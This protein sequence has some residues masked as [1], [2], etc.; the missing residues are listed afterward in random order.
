MSL[1]QYLFQPILQ[2][3][4]PK[5]LRSSTLIWWGAF[6]NVAPTASP[7]DFWGNAPCTLIEAV[8]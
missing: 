3:A 2:S 5:A 7:I 1:L 4:M 6:P 8:G